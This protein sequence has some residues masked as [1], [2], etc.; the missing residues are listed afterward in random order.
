M[1]QKLTNYIESKTGVYVYPRFV[2]SIIALLGALMVFGGVVL[3]ARIYRE[4][5]K[6]IGPDPS[7]AAEYEAQMRAGLHAPSQVD[8]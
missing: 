1:I 8:F 2:I 3:A 4:S 7:E 5:V 6:T